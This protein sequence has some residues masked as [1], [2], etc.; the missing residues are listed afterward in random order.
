MNSRPLHW[1]LVLAAVALLF[2]T[3]VQSRADE[4][5]EPAQPAGKVSF[6]KDV[7][8]IFQAHCQGCHQP[9]KRGGDYSMTTFEDLIKGGE[10]SRAIVPGKPAESSL[11]SQITLVDGKAAMP[12]EQKPLS[13]AEIQMIANWIEQGAEDDSPPSAR[14]RYDMQHPPTYEATPAITSL[15]YSPDGSLLAVS[16]YHEV[17]LHKADGSGIAARLVGVSE[18]IESAVFS[19]DGKR[20]A[21]C[22]GLP[23]R[24]GELQVWNVEKRELLLARSIGFDTLYG[25]SWSPD[26]KLIG[27][28]CPD[29]TVRAI[30]SETGEQ[31]LFNGAHDD[32]VLDTVFSTKGDHLIDVGRDGSM[33]LIHVETQRFIDNITSITPGA[34][35]GGLMTIDRHPTKDELLTAGADGTP[36]IYRMIREKARQIGDDFNLI[37][38]YP[39]MPGRVFSVAFS[40]DGERIAAGSSYNTTGE[41]RIFNYADA[42]ELLKVQF[43][44]GGI[45]AVAFSRDGTTLAAAGYDG[46]IRLIDTANGQIKMQFPP[47]PLSPRT[48]ASAK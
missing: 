38:A 21:V 40:A 44:E 39:T 41:V 29:K 37:R 47:V 43:T 13:A 18:R 4:K 27:V 30:D 24:M 36:K 28:G 17:V 45:F 31:K 22:G 11:I 1:F 14:A 8:P 34:L 48:V 46:L 26:G 20:L 16:G 15:Q 32:W 35:K 33:R 12:K 3:L 19:P 2:G 42:K 25:A 6:H 23:G 9:A 10:S 5:K 7:R